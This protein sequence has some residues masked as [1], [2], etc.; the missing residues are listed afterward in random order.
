MLILLLDPLT[1][2]DNI[3][4]EFNQFNDDGTPS[5]I[6]NFNLRVT[7]EAING[8]NVGT[9]KVNVIEPGNAAVTVRTKYGNDITEPATTS[10]T[11]NANGDYFLHVYILVPEDGHPNP[12]VLDQVV[13]ELTTQPPSTTNIITNTLSTHSAL[14]IKR[15]TTNKKY[16]IVPSTI[17]REHNQY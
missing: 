3:D 16:D 15:N 2:A 10:N 7:Y 9:V 5:N 11:V 13:A 17:N 8:N 14:S 4:I 1:G 12:R 6:Q